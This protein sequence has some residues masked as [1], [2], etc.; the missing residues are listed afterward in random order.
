M[1]YNLFQVRLSEKAKTVDNDAY[2][3]TPSKHI[4][5]IL[6]NVCFVNN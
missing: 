4:R 1:P 2:F 6:K 3:L 5:N